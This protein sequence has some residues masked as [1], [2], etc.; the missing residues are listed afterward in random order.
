[1]YVDIVISNVFIRIIFFLFFFFFSF[2]ASGNNSILDQLIHQRAQGIYRS[3]VVPTRPSSS[4]SCFET[5]PSIRESIQVL[6]RAL[7]SRPLAAIAEDTD[8][9]YLW[10]AIA[11]GTD[12]TCLCL[13]NAEDTD[14]TCLCPAIAEDTDL[15]RITAVLPRL[16]RRSRRL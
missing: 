16:Y 9:T 1:M 15:I 11:E 4:L 2:T 13:A 8:L 10:P 14:L 7:T 12:L 5:T 3:G 6:L